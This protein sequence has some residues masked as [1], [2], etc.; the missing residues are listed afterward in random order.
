MSILPRT[1][2][3]QHFA[4]R[5]SGVTRLVPAWPLKV[6]PLAF[7]SGSLRGGAKDMAATIASEVL[8]HAGR[9][10]RYF[11]FGAALVMLATV[12]AGF[13]PTFYL[14]SYVVAEVPPPFSL[15]GVFFAL[16]PWGREAFLALG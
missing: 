3:A 12:L 7:C 5:A 4:R 6:I 15:P 2:S 9:R 16:S 14:R 10:G 1:L 11:F 13:S 8:P